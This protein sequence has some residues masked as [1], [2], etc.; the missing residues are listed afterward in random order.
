MKRQELAAKTVTTSVF[1]YILT[2]LAGF[3]NRKVFDV[4]LGQELLGLNGLLSNVI[5][6]LGLLEL[7][8]TGAVGFSLY[9]PLQEKDDEQVKAILVLFG[10]VYKIIGVLVAVLGTCL[11]PL[12]PYVVKADLPFSLVVQSYL[13]FLANTVATYLVSYRRIILQASERDYINKKVDSAVFLF[14][15]LV[16]IVV[17]AVWRAYLVSLVINIV[18]CLAGNIILYKKAGQTFPLLDDKRI[19]GR[20]DDSVKAGIITNVKALFVINVASYLVFGTDNLLLSAFFGVTSVAVYSS[21]TMI[22]SLVNSLFNNV[23]SYIMPNIGN[24]IVSEPKERSYQLFQNIYFSNF[25]ICCYTSVA[26][27]VLLN[28]FIKDIWLGEE[29]TF[30]LPIVAILV[31]NNYSRFI[32][33]GTEAFRGA[34]GLYSPKPFVKYLALLEGVINILFSVLFAETLKIGVIGIFLGTTVSTLVSTVCVPWIVHKYL[35]TRSQRNYWKRYSIYLFWLA[36]CSVSSLA[37]YRLAETASGLAN[38]I[39]GIA[40][41][42]ALPF[43]ILYLRFGRTEEG[44][45]MIG[46]IRS[47]LGRIKRKQQI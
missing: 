10:R 25:V 22:I 41:S 21:Y 17:I 24:Y 16:R 27:L 44:L 37:V 23:F 40:V 3:I 32:T 5:S 14:S 34:A 42:A 43:G 4:Y 30:A 2:G 18:F 9:K 13:L 28:P 47:F 38:L 6:M 15:S 46:I 36:V 20:I 19:K 12:L 31:F 35:F 1:Y 45:W 33:K 26:M 8:I 39:I 7:G 29:Y 11:I